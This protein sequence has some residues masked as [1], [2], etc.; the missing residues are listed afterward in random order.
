M[1]FRELLD[2]GILDTIKRKVGNYKRGDGLTKI[3]WGEIKLTKDIKVDTYRN[4][5]ASDDSAESVKIT[6][7]P[8]G[9]VLSAVGGSI[10]QGYYDMVKSEDL[11]SKTPRKSTAYVIQFEKHPDEWKSFAKEIY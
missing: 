7:L 11:K 8:K 3:P 1:E 4:K 9:T 6:T 2:E 10:G 5:K